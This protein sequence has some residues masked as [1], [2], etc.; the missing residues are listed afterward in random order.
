M[1]LAS[2]ACHSR[3]NKRIV[4]TPSHDGA[5]AT[6]KKTNG[7]PRKNA[8]PAVRDWAG[9]RLAVINYGA[10]SISDGAGTKMASVQ[11]R[12]LGCYTAD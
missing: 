4:Y 12:P 5:I 7:I 10:A 3:L 1:V 11:R 8:N 9:N 6:R 2:A